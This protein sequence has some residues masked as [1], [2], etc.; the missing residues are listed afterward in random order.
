MRSYN[1]KLSGLI[2]L[3]TVAAKTSLEYAPYNSEENA[4]WRL[5]RKVDYFSIQENPSLSVI[6]HGSVILV[7][8]FAVTLSF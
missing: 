8:L 3:L 4:T 5:D 1:F 2:L 6:L 7:H